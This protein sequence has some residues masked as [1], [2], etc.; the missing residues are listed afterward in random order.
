MWFRASQPHVPFGSSK[1]QVPLC[2]PP[3]SWHPAEHLAQVQRLRTEARWSEDPRTLHFQGKFL[4]HLKQEKTLQLNVGKLFN[5]SKHL[6]LIYLRKEIRVPSSYNISEFKFK[7]SY[8]I[9]SI[10]PG[11]LKVIYIYV[12]QYYPLAYLSSVNCK[13]LSNSDVILCFFNLPWCLRHCWAYS[14]HW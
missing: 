3:C 12:Y 13:L 6:F 5:L 9:L 7:K 8:Y 2:S 10:I 1:A 14:R 11:P 4:S